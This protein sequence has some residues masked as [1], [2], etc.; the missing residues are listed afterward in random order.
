MISSVEYL[1]SCCSHKKQDCISV[2][3][4]QCFN[5]S[6]V[7]VRQLHFYSPTDPK[8]PQMCT[9]QLLCDQGAREFITFGSF[10]EVQCCFVTKWGTTWNW[11][12]WKPKSQIMVE[13]LLLISCSRYIAV[14]CLLWQPVELWPPQMTQ[15]VLVFLSWIYLVRSILSFQNLF[16]CNQ[17]NKASNQD[18]P[19]SVTR[20][21]VK[22]SHIQGLQETNMLCNSPTKQ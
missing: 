3:A 4:L 15:S 1:Q 12:R 19:N 21:R 20:H 8:P 10:S 18:K 16:W 22:M 2:C 14:I 6:D 5:I 17:T 9:D 7:F 13:S 11:E